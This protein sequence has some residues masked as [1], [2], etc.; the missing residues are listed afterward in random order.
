MGLRTI[1]LTT[2]DIR[3][4]PNPVE[5]IL[6]FDFGKGHLPVQLE[7]KDLTGRL[8]WKDELL[9][10]KFYL[11]MESYKNGIYFITLYEN[12]QFINTYKIVVQHE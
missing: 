11:N 8:V 5:N 2:K 3:V 6:T 12:N 10:G 9:S 7:V 4:Y 1:D